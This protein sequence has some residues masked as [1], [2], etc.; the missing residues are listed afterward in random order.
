MAI[1]G[2]ILN[3]E[4]GDRLTKVCLTVPRGTSFLIKDSFLFQTP[5]GTV[6]DGVIS[7]PDVVAAALSEQLKAHHAADC[8]RAIFVLTS[9][10]VAS[11]EVML[12]P[13]KD[14]R[15]QSVVE[16]NKADY[17]PVDLSKYHIT[18]SLLDRVTAGDEPGCRVLVIAA[19]LHLLDG[20][21]KTAALAGLRV[22]AIDSS[23]NSQYHAL[24]AL[25][26]EGITMYVSVDCN[27]SLVTFLQNGHLLM[28]RAFTFGGDE[29][30]LSYMSETGEEDYVAALKACETWKGE[31]DSLSR[32]VSS[33]IRASD[34]FNSN[35][36]EATVEHVVLMGPC[37]HLFGLRDMVASGTGLAIDYLSE[38][39]GIS[40]LANSAESA[41]C[42]IS[43]I[44]SSIAPLDL[45]PPQF[46]EE[47]KK[48]SSQKPDSLLG[49]IVIC[50]VC[51]LAAVA[52]SASALLGYFNA[53][54]ERDELQEKISDM[55][56]AKDV[57]SE[58]ALYQDAQN[59]VIALDDSVSS[60][61][62]D[63]LALVDELEQKMPSE[64]LML[65]AVCS[66]DSVTMSIEVPSYDDVAAVLGQLR[67]FDS[68]GTLVMS[69]VTENEDETGGTFLSFA[70]TCNYAAVEAAAAQAAA[71]QAAAATTAKTAAA[72]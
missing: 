55:S 72:N 34:Y 21:F 45:I 20:Y 47:R 46:K 43:C 28:Q 62:D 61:N 63:L 32:L 64:V 16:A 13:V 14:S 12:P 5:E 6:Q 15:L 51:F 70:V 59:A 4:I 50:G 22:E 7:A 52:L 48:S 35:R 56:Y 38:V 68:L 33:M 67:T 26:S 54:S 42:Y 30:I 58:Y 27:S 31:P 60:P 69:T 23:G 19:P 25:K 40:S 57:Y 3:I 36:W 53:R 2:K 66:Q 18:Y 8:K 49:G 24:R 71:A 9:G 29:R 1:K 41:A 10:K 44:G 65:S 37:G 11:R 39:S 17:F